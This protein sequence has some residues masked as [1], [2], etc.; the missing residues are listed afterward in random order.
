MASLAPEG[1]ARP[2]LNTVQESDEDAS[3]TSKLSKTSPSKSPE[4]RGSAD[5]GQDDDGLYEPGEDLRDPNP[6]ETVEEIQAHLVEIQAIN[7]KKRRET[8]MLEEWLSNYM[9]EARAEEDAKSH[10][11]KNEI[12]SM[13]KA[14][15]KK[16]MQKSVRGS[17]RAQSRRMTARNQTSGDNGRIKVLTPLQKLTI[18]H[19]KLTVTQNQTDQDAHTLAKKVTA[20]VDKYDAALEE[21]GDLNNRDATFCRMVDTTR[22]KSRNAAMMI[23]S[24]NGGAGSSKKRS[25]MVLDPTV[26][27]TESITQDY[28]LAARN[29]HKWAE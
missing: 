17:R 7:D 8:V 3:P 16:L 23:A 19:K 22:I 29:L 18:A 12:D 21:L 28:L 14:A 13:N 6:Y 24:A 4:G 20:T 9:L 10:A 5:A 11:G 25:S 26:V 15:Q 2:P 1:V 27:P